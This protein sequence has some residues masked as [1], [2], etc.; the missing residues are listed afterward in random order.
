MLWKAASTGS[1]DWSDDKFKVTAV[2][3][4]LVNHDVTKFASAMQQVA[5][6]VT[7]LIEAGLLTEE[8]ALLLIADIA[9]R[10]GQEIDAKA[11]LAAAKAEKATRDAKKAKDDSFNLPADQ[12]DL[13]QR[14]DAKPVVAPAVADASAA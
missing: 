14:G 11:E 7:S 3:P 6:T 13:L 9:Q 4:E 5:T 1:V 10:F 8:R 12:R 2:F